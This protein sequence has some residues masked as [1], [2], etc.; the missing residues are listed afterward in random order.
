MLTVR[1]YIEC[2]NVERLMNCLGTEID[3]AKQTILL[4]LLVE[5]GAK[6][7]Q[8]TLEGQR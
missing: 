6:Q 3:P 8:T 2:K 5:E 1:Q 4:R 7:A